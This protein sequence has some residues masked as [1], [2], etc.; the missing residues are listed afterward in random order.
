MTEIEL[1]HIGITATRDGLTT[2]QYVLASHFLDELFL[3]GGQSLVLHHGD[4]VGGDERIHQLGLEHDAIYGFVIHPP[5]DDSYR[6]FCTS[7][8]KPIEWRDPR[9][10]LVRD[11]D[12]VDETE[13]LLT[14]P[15]GMRHELRSGTW[16]TWRYGQTR[17][18][19]DP[20]YEVGIIYPD[21]TTD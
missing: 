11:Q 17:K 13:F 8:D 5:T 14:L 15:K 16:T 10:Y 21:G 12:I 1:H 2:P 4:C 7:P 20:S 19:I 3:E 18:K 9:P 6:A